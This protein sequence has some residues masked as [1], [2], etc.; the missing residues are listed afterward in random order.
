M[1][2]F[3]SSS[4]SKSISNEIQRIVKGISHFLSEN[5]IKDFLPKIVCLIY[6]KN[7][8]KYGR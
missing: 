8:K 1:K 7:K 6:N 4:K 5:I 3:K 2:L